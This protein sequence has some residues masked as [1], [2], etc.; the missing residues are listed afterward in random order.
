MIEKFRNVDD[1]ENFIFRRARQVGTLPKIEIGV[2][3]VMFGYRIRVGIVGSW[4]VELDYCAGAQQEDVE[5]I[6]S[7]TL[8]VLNNNMDGL[9]PTDRIRDIFEGFPRQDVKP[10]FNDPECFNELTKVAGKNVVK[11]ELKGL[12]QRRNQYFKSNL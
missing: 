12:K 9:Q 4:A 8:A 6:Y 10:M 7:L 1:N 11:V 5:N 3:P 2:Y